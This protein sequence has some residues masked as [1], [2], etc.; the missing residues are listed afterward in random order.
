MA[1]DDLE[2]VKEQAIPMS[3]WLLG[4]WRSHFPCWKEPYLLPRKSIGDCYAI[5][6]ESILTLEAPFPKDKLYESSCL[7]PE[8]RFHVRMNMN[9]CDYTI[10]D[11]LDGS[12]L[13]VARILVEKVN[14]NISH[15]Y[16]EQR[17]Q[18]LL[19]ND[20]ITHQHHMGDA[21]AEVAN[22]LIVDGI[23]SFYSCRNPNLGPANRF[24]I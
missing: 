23:A 17:A 22:E 3:W 8:A 2:R 19:V 4:E 7:N 16:A 5:V 24:W 6:I 9:T 14:F 1:F 20:R 18:A 12:R 10:N 21:V 13:S 11:Q 15:W